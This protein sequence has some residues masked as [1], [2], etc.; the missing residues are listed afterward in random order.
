MKREDIEHILREKGFKATIGRVALMQCMGKNREPL[1]IDEIAKKISKIL[2]EANIYRSLEAFVKAGLVRKIDFQK[3]H[4]YYEL[5]IARPHHHH[6]VC[7]KCGL[8]EDVTGC[9][10]FIQNNTLNKSKKFKT[11]DDHSLEFFGI[12]RSC[13]RA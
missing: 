5:S 6:I 11:I 13:A 1:S 4:S 10:Q 12:C 7:T 2:D 8:I 3:S 9:N